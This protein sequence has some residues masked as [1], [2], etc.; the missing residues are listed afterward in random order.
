DVRIQ[1][2]KIR[3]AGGNAIKRYTGKRVT[4]DKAAG[5]RDISSN[6]RRREVNKVVQGE[7]R[8][9]T[10]SARIHGHEQRLA[11]CR[12]Y[13]L[14]HT[15]VIGSIATEGADIEGTSTDDTAATIDNGKRPEFIAREQQ[16]SIARRTRPRV[17]DTEWQQVG[18][19]HRVLEDGLSRRIVW[20]DAGL[21]RKESQ[22]VFIRPEL[23]TIQASR[24]RVVCVLDPGLDVCLCCRQRA[25]RRRN[26]LADE[27]IYLATRGCEIGIVQ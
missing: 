3:L 12:T 24:C 6:P 16:E 18:Q 2:V 4:L 17:I 10:D 11:N 14:T 21:L 25:A 15:V 20:V 8:R 23:H 13:R 27:H 1:G 7:V 22:A 19:Q 26:N 5:K 9:Q